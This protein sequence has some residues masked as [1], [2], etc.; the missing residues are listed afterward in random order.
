VRRLFPILI[1]LFGLFALSMIG[2]SDDDEITTPTEKQVGNLNN[3]EF[4]MVVGVIEIAEGITG[5]MIDDLLDQIGRIDDINPNPK[6]AGSTLGSADVP[7]ADSFSATYNFV[8]QYWHIYLSIT[9][10]SEA[11]TFT[12]TDSVQLRNDAGPMQWPDSTINEV[13]S[14]IS[15]VAQGVANGDMVTAGQNWT[16]AGDLYNAGI[17]TVD[18]GGTLNVDITETEDSTTCEIDLAF[19][20]VYDGVEADLSNEDACPTAGTV[21][22]DGS[23]SLSC[24]EGSNSFTIADTWMA[25][26][27]FDGT[28]VSAVWENSNFRWTYDGPCDELP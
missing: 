3:A 24:T 10:T 13:R 23:V 27:T 12:Y 21:R 20:A 16:I 15:V 28:D 18:G 2:C 1:V 19:T 5:E 4:Q 22:H 6:L 26:M 17:V 14:G 9:D 11:V 7:A 25:S 8:T